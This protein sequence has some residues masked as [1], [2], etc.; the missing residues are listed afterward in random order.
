MSSYLVW[1]AQACLE[2]IWQHLSELIFVG[3][4][5]EHAAEHGGDTP[6]GEEGGTRAGQHARLGEVAARALHRHRLLQRPAAVQGVTCVSCVPPAKYFR[7]RK[8]LGS[9]WKLLS[10]RYVGRS[11]HR[12]T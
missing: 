12:I 4:G 5:A 7:G 6:E 2:Q 9:F 8:L 10:C 3:A 11:V 1:P